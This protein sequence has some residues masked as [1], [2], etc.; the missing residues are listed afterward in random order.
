[1]N[2]AHMTRLSTRRTWRYHMGNQI[3]WVSGTES[4]LDF[5]GFI[6]EQRIHGN[7]GK[8]LY[9]CSKAKTMWSF[10]TN[11]NWLF[12]DGDSC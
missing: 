1:M 11:D 7:N 8:I 6:G 3:N 12:L 9:C 2:I 5:V 10:S 4:L